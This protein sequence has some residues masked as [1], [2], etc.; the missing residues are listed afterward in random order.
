MKAV[1]LTGKLG[2]LE[3]MLFLA[4]PSRPV[5]CF[6]GCYTTV[7]KD[8]EGETVLVVSS[9]LIHGWLITPQYPNHSVT[10]AQPIMCSENKSGNYGMDHFPPSVFILYSLFTH[11]CTQKAEFRTHR[12]G[13]AFFSPTLF[14][15]LLS[16]IFLARKA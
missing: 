2:C 5:K 8:T 15:I 16:T 7:F 6:T 9:S 1:V 12:M 13:C 3:V 4:H 10:S 11:K 14:W